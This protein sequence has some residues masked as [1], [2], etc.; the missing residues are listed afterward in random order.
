ME[1]FRRCENCCSFTFGVADTI[2]KQDIR[3]CMIKNGDKYFEE[4]VSKSSMVSLA[5]RMFQTGKGN[6]VSMYSASKGSIEILE[7]SAKG[8]YT[9]TNVKEF[10][11]EEYKTKFNKNYY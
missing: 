9:S 8:Q 2:V 6:D 5:N 7:N 11:N 4:S 10:S 1:K 3:G